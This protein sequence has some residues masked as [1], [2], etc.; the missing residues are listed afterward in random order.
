MT[1]EI[2]FYLKSGEIVFDRMNS[3]IHKEAIPYINQ[4]LQ[5]INSLNRTYITEMI[6]FK[7]DIGF[8][9]CVK[10]NNDDEIIFA[11]RKGRANYTKYVKNRNPIICQSLTI[12]LIKSEVNQNVYHILTAYIGKPNMDNKWLINKKII[13]ENQ[14]LLKQAMQEFWK[15]HA[16]IY[17]EE[18]IQTETILSEKDFVKKKRTYKKGKKNPYNYY[19]KGWKKRKKRKK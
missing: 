9:Q 4:A 13:S 7:K 8:D 6:D 15:N 14:K 10:T 16:L 19:K 11:K 5:Q 2:F 1:D 3:H 18:D 17:N 12:S